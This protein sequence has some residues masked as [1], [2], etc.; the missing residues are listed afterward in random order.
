MAR[1]NC[2]YCGAPLAEEIIEEAALA[3][4]RVQKTQS[5]AHLQTVAQGQGREPQTR[6]YVIIDTS[7]AGAEA[8]ASA[9][10]V[11][12][13]E[14]RQWQAACVFRLVRVS[15]EPADGPLERRLKDQ[16]L[17]F[18]VV[19]ED[20]VARSRIPVLLES[21]DLSKVPARCSLRP[22]PEA[23]PVG[24]DL[25]ESELALIVSAPIKREKVK[26]S[27]S[28]KKAVDTRLEDAWVVHL[29]L[30]SEAR[31]W[32]IDPR[33]TGYERAGLAS[34]HMSTME[35]VRRLS[36]SVPH[37][38]TFKNMVPALSPGIDPVG[39]LAALKAPTRTAGKPPRRL[40]LDNLAQFR[41]YSA[42]RGAIER[43]R[44][45]GLWMRR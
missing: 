9:C 25:P 27:P 38:E 39:D 30:R 4:R 40:V 7:A 13:W 5:L 29:H 31:P 41:E 3:A 36:A 14:A 34:A 21:I 1:A 11:S 22:D 26:D 17:S 35:L 6:R 15:A 32:E 16:G 42:W 37:D 28:P 19:P 24:R 23:A 43:A 45:E 10:S 33:R 12:V 44:R 20:D 8:I 2:V 18:F